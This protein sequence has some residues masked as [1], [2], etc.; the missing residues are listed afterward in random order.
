M[1]RVSW[2]AP[3]FLSLRSEDAIPLQ[4]IFAS[5]KSYF[6]NFDQ[7]IGCKLEKGAAQT[8]TTGSATAITFGASDTEVFDTNNFH[9]TTANPSRITVP[10]GLA[11]KYVVTAAIGFAA[12]TTGFRYCAI[13]KNGVLDASTRVGATTISLSST[14]VT[15][16]T[17]LSLA[18]GDYVE[19][20]GFQSSGADLTV[21]AG[22]YTSLSVVYLGA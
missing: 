18:A 4:K 20:Y 10:P 9:S 11:G 12:N 8:L 5:I 14:L 22:T 13:Y 2:T 21:A 15:A 19:M 17:V 6:K 1:P 3:T 7:A 16:S